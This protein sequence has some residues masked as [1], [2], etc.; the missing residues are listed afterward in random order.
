MYFGLPVVSYDLHEAK[1]SAGPAGVFA[2]PGSEQ[3]FARVISELLDD[4]PGRQEMA[5]VGV[6]RLENQ[7][8]WEHSV[9]VLLDAY[10]TALGD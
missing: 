5:R 10:R 1:Q 2:I 9:P 4:E 7:L 3:D 6:D 8:S